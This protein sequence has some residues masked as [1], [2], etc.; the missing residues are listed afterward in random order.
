MS[1]LPTTI[2]EVNTCLEAAPK[3]VEMLREDTPRVTVGTTTASA[4]APLCAIREY[5]EPSGLSDL[6]HD[7]DVEEL[8]RALGHS[9]YAH[10]DE[11]GDAI[12][13]LFSGV[14][15]VYA[16]HLREEGL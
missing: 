2:E 3:E 5:L 15:S 8:E 14:Y 13:K 7:G 1:E 4:I 9:I 11:Y 16:V 6:P 10:G 12:L